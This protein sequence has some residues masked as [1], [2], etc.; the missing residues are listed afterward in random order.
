MTDAE[1]IKAMAQ[2]IYVELEG[3]LAN[4]D[5]SRQLRQW[6]HAQKLA[7]AAFV[8]GAPVIRAPLEA[9]IE[10]LRAALYSLNAD[11]DGIGE[12]YTAAAV[13]TMRKTIEEALA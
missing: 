3:P 11:L 7:N 10:R 9:D 2:N 1:I 13:E 12:A 8:I 6:D 5:Y 4:Q